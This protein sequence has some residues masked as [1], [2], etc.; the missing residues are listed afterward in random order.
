[1]ERRL[2]QLSNTRMSNTSTQEYFWALARAPDLHWNI[3]QLVTSSNNRAQQAIKVPDENSAT[4]LEHICMACYGTRLSR[5]SLSR[6]LDDRKTAK[7]DIS[8]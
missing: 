3:R 4:A 7:R 6:T 8:N 5:L 2:R 1:M